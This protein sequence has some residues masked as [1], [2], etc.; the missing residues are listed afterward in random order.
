MAKITE[1]AIERF[2]AK[3]TKR[4]RI[5]IGGLLAVQREK[6]K[7]ALNKIFSGLAT[8]PVS[9]KIYRALIREGCK[10]NQEEE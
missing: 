1:K 5:M 8:G 7:A 3:L 10:I 6:I 4:Q 9:K 2:A